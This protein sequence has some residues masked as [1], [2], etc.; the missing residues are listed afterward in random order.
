MKNTVSS[1]EIQDD[2]FNDT[3]KIVPRFI[4]FGYFAKLT[5]SRLHSVGHGIMLGATVSHNWSGRTERND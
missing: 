4:S 5:V 2:R 1:D 3:F